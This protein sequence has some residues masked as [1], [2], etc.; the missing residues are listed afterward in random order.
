MTTSSTGEI[1]MAKF[2]SSILG[3]TLVTACSAAPADA[4]LFDWFTGTPG[5][6]APHAGV[7]YTSPA[8]T[9]GSALCGPNG[10][11]PCVN[12]QCGTSLRPTTA[13]NGYNLHTPACNGQTP[14][15]C[16]PTSI[17]PT[18][19]YYGG[20]LYGN[21]NYGNPSYG[22]SYRTPC[23]TGNCPTAPQATPYN[24]PVNIPVNIPVSSSPY[25][26]SY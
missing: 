17:S 8:T 12:G 25:F 10:C 5:Y 26:G 21:T 22:N 6:Y 15:Q 9:H 24:T 11:V 23:A 13:P 7:S 16:F 4:G 19:T 2:T 18:T 3:L 1:A 14:N 20:T